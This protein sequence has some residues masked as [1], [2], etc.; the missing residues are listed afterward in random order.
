MTS[1]RIAS[2][3][4]VAGACSAGGAFAAAQTQLPPEKHQG[5]IAF[6]TGGIG[7][8]EAQAFKRAE[9]RFPLALEFVDRVGKRD[10]YVAGTN[11]QL[12]DQHGKK[13]LSTIADGPYLLARV[14]NGRYTV[15]ATYEDK[16]LKRQV[17]VDGKSAK[18]VVLEWKAKA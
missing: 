9:K 14:P 5:G 2:V 10:E 1:K 8:N 11:V 12:T 4:L 7:K 16:T 17:V 3:L 6:L 13:V 15:S 18:P